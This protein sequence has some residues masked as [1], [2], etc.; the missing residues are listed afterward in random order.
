MGSRCKDFPFLICVG[1][2]SEFSSNTKR[3]LNSEPKCLPSSEPERLPTSEHYLH[4][5]ANTFVYMT[6]NYSLSVS[7]RW[8]T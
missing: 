7:D 4:P 6:Q 3:L 8:V 5:G 2:C 1:Q